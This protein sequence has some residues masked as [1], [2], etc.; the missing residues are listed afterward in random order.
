MK[1]FFLLIAGSVLLGSCQKET[2]QP[3]QTVQVSE[4]KLFSY[5]GVLDAANG[6]YWLDV[7]PTGLHATVVLENQTHN[8][9]ASQTI[10]TGNDIPAIRL[11]DGTV[12]LSYS[13][14]Y[15]SGTPSI[16]VATPTRKL[17]TIIGT[18]YDYR[19][20]ETTLKAAPIALYTGTQTLIDCPA[21]GD[22]IYNLSLDHASK[23]Y[24]ILIKKKDVPAAETQ[25]LAGYFWET[26]SAIELGS[27]NPWTIRTGHSYNEFSFDLQKKGT[28]LACDLSATE[29]SERN[30]CITK[31]RLEKH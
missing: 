18:S 23:K 26:P 28:G 19:S 4:A 3:A 1:H 25:L 6:H 24:A 27:D 12:T 22:Y 29:A 7:R 5:G 11:T 13:Y 17:A 21:A 10:R 16:S 8:L 9:N 20:S 2:I 30:T 31:I 14:D 15:A